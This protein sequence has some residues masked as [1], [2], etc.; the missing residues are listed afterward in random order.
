[1]NGFIF[2]TLSGCD[3][4]SSQF[5]ATVA[6][7]WKHLSSVLFG[8]VVAFFFFIQCGESIYES[9]RIKFTL[10]HLQYINWTESKMKSLPLVDVSKFS[11][12]LERNDLKSLS[13]I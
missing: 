7:Y 13:I 10:W 9:P 12:Y 1:M 6:A 11:W 8:F 4:I 5:N 3:S 2:Q